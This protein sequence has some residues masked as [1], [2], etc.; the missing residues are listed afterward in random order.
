MSKWNQYVE[1]VNEVNSKPHASVPGVEKPLMHHEDECCPDDGKGC[2]CDYD[3]S[4][5][6]A[7]GDTHE[8]EE[9]VEEYSTEDEMLENVTEEDLDDEGKEV[10][11]AVARTMAQLKKKKKEAL[12]KKKELAKSK[13]MSVA[14]LDKE[15]KKQRKKADPT[16][17]KAKL[18]QKKYK[19]TSKGKQAK[20]IAD[21]R[22]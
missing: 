6:E 3:E 14:Q 15:R 11:E 16:G 1:V 19:K 22:K 12:L 4:V 20:K 10:Y 9:V 21:K 5:E 7:C 2:V 17:K 13:G 18:A 8:E